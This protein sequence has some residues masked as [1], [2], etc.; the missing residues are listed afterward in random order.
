VPFKSLDLQAHA[1]H[2]DVAIVGDSCLELADL[3]HVD[4]VARRV[5]VDDAQ[6]DA[7]DDVAFQ[8]IAEI[9]E[10]WCHGSLL[11][12]AINSLPDRV[13]ITDYAKVARSRTRLRDRWP[14]PY[15]HEP[16]K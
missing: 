1:D 14:A 2:L 15:R 6:R 9:F 10:E 3:F 7:V 12:R 5:D 11:V 13:S 8:G 16:L 4:G